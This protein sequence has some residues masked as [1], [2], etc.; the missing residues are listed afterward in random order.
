LTLIR[1]TFAS[2]AA[3]YLAVTLRLKDSD[4]AMLSMF[5]PLFGTFSTVAGGWAVDRS[6]PGRRGLIPVV[7][8]AGLTMLL[9]S[10]TFFMTES[11]SK[12]P[13]SGTFCHPY[14]S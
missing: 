6:S 2:W 4:A 1:E 11:S 13:A 3:V 5:F 8:L 12:E 7:C 10:S 14:P 9:M